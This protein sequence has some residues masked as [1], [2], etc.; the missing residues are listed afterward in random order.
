MAGMAVAK[1]RFS[2]AGRTV[3]VTG[4]SRGIGAMLARGFV[5]ADA[6]VIISA[7]SVAACEE[8]AADLS[9]IGP[10]EAVPADLGTVEGV[11]RL[12]AAVR[13]RWSKLDVLINN[14]GAAWGA[15]FEE[16]PLEALDKLWRINVK[17]VFALT[18]SLLPS[19]RQAASPEEPS[20]VINIGS[21][22]GLR[23]PFFDNYGYSSTKAAVHMLTRHLASALATEQITVNAIAPGPFHSHMMASVLDDEETGAE[24]LA[25]VPLGRLGAPEDV[26]GLAI[27]LAGPASA[28][29]TGAVIPL[30]GGLS[31]AN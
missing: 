7:R 2:V 21:V 15:P 19:L 9:Q 14:A 27:F 24:I 16:Y 5:E 23:V 1:Q 22:D 8:T 10:C 28:W 3:V 13:R 26:A 29:M 30:D 17:G 12:A 25:K 4:G 31:T 18:Q 11:E 20:R 6:E